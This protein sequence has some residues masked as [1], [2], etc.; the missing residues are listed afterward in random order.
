MTIISRK[1]RPEVQATPSPRIYLNPTPDC[2]S[3]REESQYAV[4]LMGRQ[5]TI[6]LDIPLNQMQ[7]T[8]CIDN[9]RNFAWPQCKCSLLKGSLHVTLSKVSQVSVLASTAAVGLGGGQVA[10]RD[11]AA[12]DARL[13]A[14]DDFAGFVFGSS[15]LSLLKGAGKKKKRVSTNFSVPNQFPRPC[16]CHP[17]SYLRRASA[18]RCAGEA[19]SPAHI[20][21]GCI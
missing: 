13:V 10:E 2:E 3:T 14:L 1:T 11:L 18:S 17:N 4:T 5:K 7:P 6:G 15:D 16:H 12:L 19:P 8:C 9:S 21:L 20:L